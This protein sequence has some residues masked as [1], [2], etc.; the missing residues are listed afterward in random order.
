[1]FKNIGLGLLG[2]LCFPALIICS[3]ATAL[4]IIWVLDSGGWWFGV[5]A[6]IVAAPFASRAWR[7]L[8]ESEEKEQRDRSM[9]I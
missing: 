2:L 5:P 4:A 1:M 9:H 3:A 8:R 7:A 6:L